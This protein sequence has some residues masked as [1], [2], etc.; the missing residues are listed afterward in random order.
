[1]KLVDCSIT[2]AHGRVNNVLV[3][4]HMTFMP[5]DFII[6]DMD[7][8]HHSPIILGRSFLIT[9]CATTDAKE[10]NIKFQFPHKMCTEHFSRKNERSKNYPHGMCNS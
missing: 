10:G 5:V 7:G 2:D 4:L 9:I 8:K 1:L 6:I 3:E